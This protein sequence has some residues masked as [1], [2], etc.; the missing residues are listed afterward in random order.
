VD[1]LNPGLLLIGQ[2][3]PTS[4]G[5][6]IDLLAT[7]AQGHVVVIELKRDRTPREGVVQVL[8]DGSWVRCPTNGGADLP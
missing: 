7:D 6:F 3:V 2:Q 8:D 4:H 5:K 1:I